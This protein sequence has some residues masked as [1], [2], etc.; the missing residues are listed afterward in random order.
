MKIYNFT[1]HE[2]TIVTGAEFRPEIRKYVRTDR[3]ETVTAIP[4]SGV[5]S[6][7][8][9]SCDLE[10]INGIPVIGKKITACDPL[11]AEVGDGDIVIVSALYATA[12][13]RI[14]GND[15]RLYTIADPVYVIDGRA[16]TIIGCRGICPVF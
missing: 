6:A 16:T 10:P 13:T 14:H 7:R 12:F 5:L 4:S 8:I 3:T 11:P 9:E 1:P 15:A 2:V